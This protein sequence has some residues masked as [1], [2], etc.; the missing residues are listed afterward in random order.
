[1]NE[2]YIFDTLEEFEIARDYINSQSFFPCRRKGCV[3][4]TENWIVEPLLLEDG[5]FAIPRLPS[6]LASEFGVSI[7][8]VTAIRNK[9]GKNIQV[10]DNQHFKKVISN[11]E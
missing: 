3:K 5:R 4:D 10:L 11:E 7:Q 9:V 6:F 8:K 2:Y 1:M